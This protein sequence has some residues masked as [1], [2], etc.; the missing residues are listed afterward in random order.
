MISLVKEKIILAPQYLHA[1]GWCNMSQRYSS[2]VYYFLMNSLITSS[3]SIVFI[4]Y[5]YCQCQLSF[6]RICNI[7]NIIFHNWHC[8]NIDDI[9]WYKQWQQTDQREILLCNPNCYESQT[10]MNARLFD[11]LC[12]TRFWLFLIF[13]FNSVSTEIVIW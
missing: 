9:R 2:V 5:K 6:L 11:S 4:V 8:I 7:N 3:K 13:N 1:S 10:H 12:S